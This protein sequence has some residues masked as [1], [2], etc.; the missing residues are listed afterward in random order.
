M[1][2]RTL[3][4]ASTSLKGGYHKIFFLVSGA[5]DYKGLSKNELKICIGEKES[6]CKNAKK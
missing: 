3:Q 6:S 4:E 5:L 1:E 2:T